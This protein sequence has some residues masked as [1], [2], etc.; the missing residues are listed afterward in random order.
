MEEQKITDVDKI[1]MAEAYR[2]Y[3]LLPLDEQAK[4]PE[5]F[6]DRLVLYVDFKK[7]K[8]FKN[9]EEMMSYNLS[10]EAMYLIMYMCTFK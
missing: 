4:I 6:V 2:V 5:D 10:D 3:Q 8:P 1:A 7:V 9:K